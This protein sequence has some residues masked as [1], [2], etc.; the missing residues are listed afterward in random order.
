MINPSLGRQLFLQLPP[1]VCAHVSCSQAIQ[2]LFRVYHHVI[3]LGSLMVSIRAI[4]SENRHTTLE[5]ENVQFVQCSTKLPRRTGL[6][7][8]PAI[9]FH[10][11]RS[12]LCTPTLCYVS[13]RFSP[14]WWSSVSCQHLQL[15]ECRAQLHF[16]ASDPM[17]LQC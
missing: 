17:P 14:I 1:N 16:P 13:S 6:P 9:C 3:Q 10:V 11:P 4:Q 5:R 7:G 15:L 2:I 12:E 8:T